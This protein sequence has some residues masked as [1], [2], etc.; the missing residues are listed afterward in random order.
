MNLQTVLETNIIGTTSSSPKL[1]M[2]T[3]GNENKL[4]VQIDPEG[5]RDCQD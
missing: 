1:A 5:S 3:S 4:R 2:R